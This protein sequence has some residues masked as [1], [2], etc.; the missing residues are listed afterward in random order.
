MKKLW[1][2]GLVIT[3]LLDLV[4]IGVL[5]A[6]IIMQ[7]SDKSSEHESTH[8]SAKLGTLETEYKLLQDENAALSARLQNI[9]QGC[10][11]TL[12]FEDTGVKYFCS[13]FRV[14]QMI[15]QKA[16]GNPKT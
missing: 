15:L 11:G 16:K 1:T 5:V 7:L 14:F 2:K 12:M 10:T 8:A 9:A 13:D 4:V 6:L 3:I